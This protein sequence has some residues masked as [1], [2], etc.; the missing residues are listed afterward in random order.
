MAKQLPSL[1]FSESVIRYMTRL[2]LEHKAVNLSQGFPNEHPESGMQ[3]EAIAAMA[4]GTAEQMERLKEVRLSP[5]HLIR[6]MGLDTED[7]LQHKT[8]KDL[9]LSLRGD[10]DIYNQYSIPFGLPELR[11]TIADYYETFYSFRPDPDTEI[12]VTLGATEGISSALRAITQPGDGVVVLQPHHEMYVN[13]VRAFYCKCEF[14]SLRENK[15]NGAW[16]LDMDE[17]ESV[18]RLPHVKGFICNS[19]HNPTGKVFSKKE[20]EQLCSLC[21]KHNVYILTD[22]IYEHIIYEPKPRSSD[23]SEEVH[24]CLFGWSKVRHLVICVNSCS[25]TGSATGWR[26][27]WTLAID[28]LTKR[29]RSVHD[30]L[31]MQ[32]PTPLQMGVINLLQAPREL[33]D[34][35]R[36]SYQEKRDFMCNEL[37]RLGFELSTPQG[38]YY[39]FVRYSKINPIRKLSPTEAAEY[40]VRNVGVAVVPGDNFYSE[41]CADKN[42]YL[43]IAFCKQHAQ[44][45]ES[46]RRLEAALSLD[47]CCI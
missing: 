39:L 40:L 29:I 34:A 6:Q 12:T 32:A 5:E 33:F 10:V 31:V 8:L 19:P 30:T 28:S 37:R 15:E 21:L 3:W 20:M 41:D 17:I 47:D 36:R 44:L 7:E 24:Y 43:R 45:R 46:I 26:V 25:K 11:R 1:G 22:E 27:G 2:A 16:D 35:I 23:G 14:A 18:L 4:A 42:K 9:L 38:S 13:Q